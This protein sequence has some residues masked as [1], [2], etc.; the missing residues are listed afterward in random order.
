VKKLG[1]YGV[2]SFGLGIAALLLTFASGFEPCGPTTALGRFL[3]SVGSIAIIGGVL[4]MVGAMFRA[5]F[6]RK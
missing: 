5:A 1:T 3:V 4:M 6:E 2:T